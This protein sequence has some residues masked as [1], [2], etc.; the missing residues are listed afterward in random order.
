MK[1][2]VDALPQEPR[3]CLFAIHNTINKDVTPVCKLM[4]SSSFD[5]E[6]GITFSGGK[7]GNGCRLCFNQHCPFLRKHMYD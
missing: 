3:E 1:I 6:G 2:L 4:L 7:N 5:W